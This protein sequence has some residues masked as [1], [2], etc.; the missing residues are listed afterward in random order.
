MS[1]LARQPS[2]MYWRRGLNIYLD[3]LFF[4]EVLRGV[5]LIN[6]TERRKYLEPF[7]SFWRAPRSSRTRNDHVGPCLRLS[8]NGKI[9]ST[10]R[11]STPKLG[12]PGS[13]TYR[14]YRHPN[15]WN[16]FYLSWGV[17]QGSPYRPYDFNRKFITWRNCWHFSPS[18]ESDL[19][20]PRS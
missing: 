10:L 11:I 16:K 15:T 20:I 13:P 3:F 1:W 8:K 18:W 17:I 9:F 2:Q 12:S 19:S 5:R 7:S 14:P 4:T 6:V